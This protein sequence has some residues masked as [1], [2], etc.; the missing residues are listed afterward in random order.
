MMSRW[1][2]SFV[3]SSVYLS[4]GNGN[5]SHRVGYNVLKRRYTILIQYVALLYK[6]Y[7]NSVGTLE[8]TIGVVQWKW[9]ALRL[10]TKN[11]YKMHDSSSI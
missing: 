9:L 8:V 7:I 3:K 10:Q 5:E 2:I 4:I 6:K 11:M 1:S